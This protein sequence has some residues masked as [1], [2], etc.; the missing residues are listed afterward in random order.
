MEYLLVAYWRLTHGVVM[1]LMSVKVVEKNGH[2]MDVVPEMV[3]VS[4]G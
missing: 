3:A 4:L 1:T 2:Y